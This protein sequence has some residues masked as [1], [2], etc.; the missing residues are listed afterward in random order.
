M[1]TQKGEA[2]KGSLKSTITVSLTNYLDAGAIVAGASGLTLWQNYL[3]LSESHLGLLNAISANCFGAALGAIIGGRLADKYGRKTIY[4]RNMLIYML[5]VGIIM[6]SVNFP[7]LLLGFLIT[8]IAVGIGVPPSWTYISETSEATNRGRNIGI[9]Q[10]AWS[11]GPAI[12][13]LLGWLVSPTGPLGNEVRSLGSWML[14]T[15]DSVH[16]EDGK[17][18]PIRTNADAEAET[19]NWKNSI[20]VA[21]KNAEDTNIKMTWDKYSGN[22]TN[23]FGGYFLEWKQRTENTENWSDAQSYG[24]AWLGGSAHEHEITKL[25]KNT[26]YDFCLTAMDDHGTRTKKLDLFGNRLIFFTLFVVAFIAWR[27]QRR[28]HESAESAEQ[29]AQ[30][31]GKIQGNAYKELLSSLTNIKAVT[32]L[33]GI[34]L[35]WNFV[36]GAMGFFM[37]H[38][39]ET[40]GGLSNES[41]NFL[42]MAMW[43]LTALFSFVGFG[44]LADKVDQRLLYA[45]GT[46]LGLAAW[47]ILTFVGI[48]NYAAIWAFVFLWGVHAGFGVQAFYALWASELFHARYRAAAQGLMF[49]MVRGGAAIWSLIFT[50]VF[51][52]AGFY[53]AGVMMVG[54]L[55]FALVVGVIWTPNTRGK[56]LKQISEERYG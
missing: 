7:M 29:K 30:D 45:F 53:T 15:K 46:S 1:E 40:A 47:V 4:S 52:M 2:Q 8:G 24:S 38:V 31:T 50:G 34:Y 48:T 22:H 41:A 3:G 36:A 17:Y 33:V 49:F 42:Q 19:Q 11:V 6:F 51:H 35:T 44:L 32:F 10:L 23:E 27:L 9:S 56:T 20:R 37:P 16:L 5:G 54:L 55:V 26:H 21:S 14:Q 39:Y 12:I 18:T 13:F 25:K 43:S 28:L